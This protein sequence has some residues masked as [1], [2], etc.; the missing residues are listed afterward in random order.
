MYVVCFVCNVSLGVYLRGLPCTALIYFSLSVDYCQLLEL[1][2]PSMSVVFFTLLNPDPLFLGY[3]FIHDIPRPFSTKP[4]SCSA[5]DTPRNTFVFRQWGTSH[6][7]VIPGDDYLS[8]GYI[9]AG[10]LTDYIHTCI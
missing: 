4:T 5:I 6:V 2:F 9:G 7:V 10:P 3:G 8:A 1:S